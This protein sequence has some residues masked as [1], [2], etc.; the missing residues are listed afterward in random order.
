MLSSNVFIFGYISV[1]LLYLL[2]NAI[3]SLQYKIVKNI[4]LIRRRSRFS[5]FWAAGASECGFPPNTSAFC[6]LSKMPQSVCVCLANLIGTTR[7]LTSLARVRYHHKNIPFVCVC[8]S[9]YVWILHR[10]Y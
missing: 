8:V 2:R 3:C 1:P 4:E 9:M 6:H 10:Q 5:P 7:T